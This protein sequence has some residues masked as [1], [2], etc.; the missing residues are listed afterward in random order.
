MIKTLHPRFATIALCT[1]CVACSDPV[2]WID[3]DTWPPEDQRD[4]MEATR[5][6]FFA[7]SSPRDTVTGYG[8]SRPRP[9]EGRP[10][11]WQQCEDT[12]REV[13]YQERPSRLEAYYWCTVE[14]QLIEIKVCVLNKF[15]L[16]DWAFSFW[17]GNIY[18]Q[19]YVYT[20]PG[21]TTENWPG[22]ATIGMC[23]VEAE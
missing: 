8:E 7:G 12:H 4:V 17:G 3:Y 13:L 15:T 5:Q 18:R 22:Q 6:S 23:G 11:F 10:S 20:Y 1:L 9:P 21:P 14:D 16:G 2:P 19:M